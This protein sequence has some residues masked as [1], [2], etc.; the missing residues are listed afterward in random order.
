M[1]RPGVQFCAAYLS[2]VAPAEGSHKT[3]FEDIKDGQLKALLQKYGKVFQKPTGMPPERKTVH[4]IET[5]EGA[6][7]TVRRG[8]R[9]SPMELEETRTHIEGLLQKG[10]V[11]WSSSPYS[12]PIIFMPKKNGLMRIC[13][14]YRMLNEITKKDRATLPR[15][16]EMLDQLGGSTLFSKIDLAQGYHQVRIR[17]GDQEKTAFTCALGHYEWTVMP[18]GLTNAPAT[19]VRGMTEVLQDLLFKGVI[20]Y[21]DDILIYAKNRQEHDKLLE[22]VLKRLQ[23]H[24]LRAQ[25]DK[26][27]FLQTEMEYLGHRVSSDGVRPEPKLTQAVREWPRPQNIKEVRSFLGTCGFYRRFIP[28]FSELAARLTDLLRLSSRTLRPGNSNWN[29]CFLCEEG[30][31]TPKTRCV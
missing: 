29:L 13:I 28:K 22:E 24:D 9:M 19:F 31:V 8:W 5:A 4:A 15:I 20:V 27:D 14:D 25:I 11:R 10:W 7:P 3:E 2:R 30:M 26:C 23:Q 12:A 18:F 21:L 6:Q 17:E 16:P 1:Q